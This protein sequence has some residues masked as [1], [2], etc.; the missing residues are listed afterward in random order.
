MPWITKAECSERN[1]LLFLPKPG[2]TLLRNATCRHQSLEDLQTSKNSRLLLTQCGMVADRVPSESMICNPWSR[3]PMPVYGIAVAALGKQM[4]CGRALHW[5]SVRYGGDFHGRH[6][7]LRLG[8]IRTN[9]AYVGTMAAQDS[10]TRQAQQLK[11]WDNG[12]ARLHDN[13]NLHLAFE[14]AVAIRVHVS[15]L[16]QRTST[17]GLAAMPPHCAPYVRVHW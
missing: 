2:I 1:V 16:R 14:T 11:R 13:I 4:T 9:N 8:N 5:S 10:S 15:V 7:R 3:I 17:A 6:D 12:T